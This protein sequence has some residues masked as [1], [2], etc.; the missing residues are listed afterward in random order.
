M[1]NTPEGDKAMAYHHWQSPASDA[2]LICCH[3]LTH[4]G[5]FFDELAS[6]LADRYHVICPDVLGRGD[7]AW[8]E[9]GEHYGYPLYVSIATQLIQTVQQHLQISQLDWLGTS[10]GGL[11]GLLLEASQPGCVRKLV[12]NDVGIHIPLAALQR[13]GAYVGQKRSF[14]SL[15]EAEAEFRIIAAPFGALTDAQWRALTLRMFRQNS[16]GD[17]HYRYDPQISLAFNDLQQDVD[18]S[19]PWQA[20]QCPVLV[21][22]GSNSDVLT[23]D[24]AALMGQREGVDVIEMTGCGHAPTLMSADQ[25]QLVK[26]YLSF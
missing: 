26:Q 4:N 20:V 7:S 12:L 14:A 23:A 21:L 15:D 10:M 8:L 16:G 9:Q 22:R 24:T 18:L 25:I 19:V 11:I 2:L 5:R 17:W 6:E 13:I 3:G 1:V